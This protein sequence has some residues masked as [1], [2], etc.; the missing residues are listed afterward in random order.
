MNE[1]FAC[2]VG[3]SVPK[4]SEQC[5]AV[6][7]GSVAHRLHRCLIHFGERL[8]SKSKR[9]VQLLVTVDGDGCTV[10]EI[11]ALVFN[12]EPFTIRE[13]STWG[14]VE[15]KLGHATRL[16]S[17]NEKAVIRLIEAAQ[18]KAKSV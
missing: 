6:G 13:G 5:C 1:V 2:Q 4:C 11:K 14:S 17:G 12:N 8:Q 18:T 10:A 16:N 7:P 9:P 15:F 3:C